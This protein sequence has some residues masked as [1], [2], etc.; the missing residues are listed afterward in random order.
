MNDYNEQFESIDKY[1]EHNENYLG[2]NSSVGYEGLRELSRYNKQRKKICSLYSLRCIW[3]LLSVI[4]A[5]FLLFILVTNI[6]II[7]DDGFNVFVLLIYVPVFLVYGFSPNT[8]HI[9]VYYKIIAE[10]LL[11]KFK[12]SSES[13]TR[14]SQWFKESCA[15]L[16][17]LRTEHQ[18][19]RESYTEL[20]KQNKELKKQVREL[21]EQLK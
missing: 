3:T 18:S 7:S 19:L 20:E 4:V 1:I 6:P 10:H 8:E 5:P 15:E 11:R 21:K 13:S 9:L 16:K 2:S 17:E 12:E 14:S